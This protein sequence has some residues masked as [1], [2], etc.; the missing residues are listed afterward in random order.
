MNAK[1]LKL[2]RSSV[3]NMMTKEHVRESLATIE[4]RKATS[5]NQETKEAEAITSKPQAKPGGTAGKN[6]RCKHLRL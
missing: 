6:D 5:V 3:R 1:D 4:A 2:T